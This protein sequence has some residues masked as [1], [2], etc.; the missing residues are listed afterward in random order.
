MEPLPQTPQSAEHLAMA[1]LSQI[2]SGPVQPYSDCRGVVAITQQT[3]EQQRGLKLKYAG[4]RN[5]LFAWDSHGF[6]RLALYTPA[7][8]SDEEILALPSAERRIA[9][10]NQWVDAQAKLALSIHPAPATALEVEM[11]KLL[12]RAKLVANT[13]AAHLDSAAAARHRRRRGRHNRHRVVVG[14]VGAAGAEA[15]VVAA[16]AIAIVWLAHTTPTGRR[17]V[18]C[19]RSRQ[20]AVLVLARWHTQATP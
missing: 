15:N 4:V 8:R 1:V 7:H 14:R 6:V 12:S 18:V 19:S 17:A 9:R 10:G 3:P 5:S 16:P 20:R 11:R 13:I 2:A